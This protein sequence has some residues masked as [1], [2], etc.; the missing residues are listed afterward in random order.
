MRKLATA[1]AKENLFSEK[2]RQ[3]ILTVQKLR[4]KGDRRSL[5]DVLGPNVRS[6]KSQVKAKVQGLIAS[7]VYVLPVLDEF[8]EAD[9]EEM[10]LRGTLGAMIAWSVARQGEWNARMFAAQIEMGLREWIA[11]KLAGSAEAIV[12]VD[13]RLKADFA[14]Q[15]LREPVM[16][17]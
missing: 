10:F 7:L 8:K 2:E 11:Q 1:M 13:I 9:L 14:D 16:N 12:T 6:Y 3:W 15:L 17:R 4:A 5:S